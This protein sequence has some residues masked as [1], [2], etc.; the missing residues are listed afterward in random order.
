MADKLSLF[1]S[2]SSLW[3]GAVS[4][5]VLIGLVCGFLGIYVVLHR[6]VFVSA[7]MSQVSSLGV[8][9]AFYLA[10]LFGHESAHPAEDI[11]PMVLA[12]AFTGIFS[13]A[14]AGS[15]A[16]RISDRSK[17][18]EALIGAV[19]LFSTAGLLLIGDR[20]T[21]GAH[22]VS[23]ILFGNAVTVDTPHLIFLGAVALPILIAHAWLKKDV[24]LVSYDP[25]TAKTL[26]YPVGALRVFLIVS[27]GIL[28][29]VGTRTIGAVPVFSFSVLP[30]I[31]ALALFS[32][33]NRSFLASALIGGASAFLGY[34][35]S[36]LFSFPTGACMT[37]TASAFL[38]IASLARR[39]KPQRL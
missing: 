32:D 6:I 34:L 35:A 30:P 1:L 19:Y 24:L 12:S 11:L 25:A 9:A 36:F 13:V 38:V 22:D 15:A 20:V 33:L 23:N 21:Q 17:S 31:A 2:S 7:A 8:M 10:Q 26:G 4:A 29:S 3:G 37:A 27:L 16:K 39:L 28:I 18:A 5:G 14:L